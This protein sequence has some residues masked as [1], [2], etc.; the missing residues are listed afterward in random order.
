[1]G[2]AA[3]A[4]DA[5]TTDVTD[6]ADGNTDAPIPPSTSP[7]NST[8]GNSTPPPEVQVN[9]YDYPGGTPQ[10]HAQDATGSIVTTDVSAKIRGFDVKPRLA[11]EQV[12]ELV[13]HSH[14]TN[15][16]YLFFTI[17]LADDLANGTVVVI[18]AQVTVDTGAPVVIPETTYTID[19]APPA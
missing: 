14:G 13:P 8:P 9:D 6:V 11:K 3:P 1:A 4:N 15:D 2:P 18:D 7:G 12:V 17:N 16:P 19:N 5:P 10:G